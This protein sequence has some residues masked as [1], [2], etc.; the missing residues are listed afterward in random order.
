MTE[1]KNKSRIKLLK[2]NIIIRSLASQTSD[3][4]LLRIF[5]ITLPPVAITI[6]I[7]IRQNVQAIQASVYFS[8]KFYYNKHTNMYR[9]KVIRY[10]FKLFL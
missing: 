1:S 3:L 8:D 5:A 6:T 2:V 10:I 4:L 9:C 7:I